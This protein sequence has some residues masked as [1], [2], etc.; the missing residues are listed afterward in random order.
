MVVHN[1]TTLTNE[2]AFDALLKETRSNYFFRFILSA[3]VTVFGLVILLYGYIQEDSNYIITGYLFLIFGL[4]YFAMSIY[5]TLSA[6]KKVRMRN[7]EI[8]ENGITY[9]YT[10]KEQSFEVVAITSERKNKLPYK[11]YDVKKIKE[12]EDKYQINLKSRFILYVKKSGF[13]NEK[14]E[15]F[16]KKNITI[17][18]LKIINKIK[19]E[20]N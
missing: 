5:A 20:N 15:Q 1:K 10:F 13:E 6:P 9:N 14:M 4:L 17:N 7:Q 19:A 16:F 8:C 2:E 12:F 3:V 11:Y 18:K